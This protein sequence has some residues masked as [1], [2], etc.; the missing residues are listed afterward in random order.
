MDP[1]L[2][3][4]NERGIAFTV[5]GRD[6]LIKCLNPEHEDSNPSCR[7]DKITGV[8][9]CFSCGWKRNLFKH[10]G[11]FT[12]FS[13]IRVAKLKEKISELKQSTI[14]LEMPKN[15]VPFNTSFRGISAQ[16]LKHFEA[17]TSSIEEL[18][19]RIVFPIK[20]IVDRTVVFVGRHLM[21][22]SNPR[23]VNYP[24][25]SQI[26][27]YPLK[28]EDRHSSVILV[29]GIFD[30]LNLYDK[31][32]KNVVACFGTQTLKTN[33]NEKLLA[34][35]AQGINEIHIMFDGDDAG[36]AA[37]KE[38]KPLLESCGFSVKTIDLPDEMDPGDLSQE[39]VDSIREYIN[40]RRN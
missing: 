32:L 28:F 14:D 40:D 9:H 27:L 25:G 37:T 23:Y 35:K 15:S 1:V 38:V 2:A 10:F 21:S 39:Y 20:D 22:N 34:L 24:R 4:L 11:V 18:Q 3:L 33:T 16:T 12:N 5:S 29:E 7:V 13:S 17:F 36:K 19:D 26:P 8:T 30:M 31:G 6:Y